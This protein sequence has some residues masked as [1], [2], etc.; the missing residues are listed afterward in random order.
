M[1]KQKQLGLGKIE[2][3]EDLR[4]L[5]EDAQY[6]VRQCDHR[7]ILEKYYYP[8]FDGVKSKNIFWEELAKFTAPCSNI[9]VEEIIKN[10]RKIIGYKPILWVEQQFFSDASIEDLEKEIA[11]VDE[12][13]NYDYDY[14]DYGYDYNDYYYDNLTN[15]I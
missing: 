10:C 13:E 3:F 4:T 11:A 15:I 8:I 7:M 9:A 14:D 5:P 6:I 12:D 2:Y 1:K